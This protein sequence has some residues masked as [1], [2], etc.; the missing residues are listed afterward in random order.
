MPKSKLHNYY[1]KI[2]LHDVDHKWLI[3]YMNSPQI[4]Y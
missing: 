4:P 3:F 1:V 2:I